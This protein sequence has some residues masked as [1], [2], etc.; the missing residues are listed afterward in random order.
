MSHQGLDVGVKAIEKS[1][2]IPR[3][4]V[5]TTGLLRQEDL[6]KS[7]ILYFNTENTKHGTKRAVRPMNFFR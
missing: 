4:L 7:S 3:S 1:K 2:M 6:G 5:C